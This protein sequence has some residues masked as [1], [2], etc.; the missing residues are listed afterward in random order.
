MRRCIVQYDCTLHIFLILL[1]RSVAAAFSG[2]TRNKSESHRDDTSKKAPVLVVGYAT[3]FL[4]T[5]SSVVN[6][7]LRRWCWGKKTEAM[8]THVTLDVDVTS[9][10]ANARGSSRIGREGTVV[11]DGET[12]P[13]N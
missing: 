5:C 4:A 13:G 8:L 2:T 6:F 3:R 9:T 1:T 7:G 10:C 12:E 11:G